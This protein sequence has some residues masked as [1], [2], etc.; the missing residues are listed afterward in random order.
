M[1]TRLVVADTGPLNYLILVEAI[2]VL[3]RLFAQVLVP[4]AVYDELTHSDAPTPVRAFIAHKPP[5]LEVRPNPDRSGDDGID[6]ALDEGERAAIALA[7]SIRADLILMDDRAGVAAAYRYGL[8]V[9]GTLGVLDLAARRGLVDL[10]AIFAK[11]A[12]TNFRYPPEIMDA[13]LAQHRK[14]T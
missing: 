3:P 9:T 5:W 7:R 10:E 8:T 14:K 1:P 6:P 12:A 11:L 13:L 2:D 4:A